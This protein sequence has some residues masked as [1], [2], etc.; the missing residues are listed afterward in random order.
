MN[1]P[2]YLDEAFEIARDFSAETLNGNNHEAIEAIRTRR[3]QLVGRILEAGTA[4]D[5]GIKDKIIEIFDTVGLSHVQQPAADP[6]GDQSGQ[7][8]YPPEPI[9]DTSNIQ[10]LSLDQ[11]GK[12]LGLTIKRDAHNK[13][14]TFLCE[15]SAYTEDSQFNILF[16]AP[17]S[18][19]KSFLPTEIAALFPLSDVKEIGYCTPTAFFHD[20]GQLIKEKGGY[21]VDLSRKILIFLDQPHNLLLEHLRPLLSHDKKEI[22]IKI[23]DKGQ[24]HGLKTKN[25]D[26]IGFPSVIFC[27]TG[28]KTDE[29]EATRFIIL[30]PESSDEK[31]RE[32]VAAK[33]KK[34]SNR[35][36]FDAWLEQNPER[37]VL[38]DRILAVKQ[39]GIAF[40]NIENP[41][42]IESMFWD[43][44]KNSKPRYQRDIGRIVSIVKSLALLNLWFRDRAGN[45]ITANDQDIDQA[46][47][48]WDKISAAQELNLSPYLLD[49]YNRVFLPLWKE[50]DG[51]GLKKNEIIKKFEEI[52][53]RPLS[54]EDYRKKVIPALDRA[55]LILT[56]PDPDDRRGKI[57][58]SP[59]HLKPENYIGSDG[60]VDGQNGQ[61]SFEI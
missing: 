28:Q 1:T 2:T 23:T 50:K 56:E 39:S 60:V 17:S 42:K 4:V 41:E 29:Q 13:I 31:I 9:I 21:V 8:V 47:E 46:F 20:H 12:V 6:Q 27:T 52:L 61:D 26:L 48:L 24:K 33:V 58:R 49:V 25:I 5:Q 19:G 32:A 30:S 14:I 34:E 53:R 3:N 36:R 59:D 54:D 51:G 45:T 38:K 44:H 35:A 57:V 37:K 10:P 7:P 18:T 15:L 55:G 22:R 40:I 11:L 43:R 16:S